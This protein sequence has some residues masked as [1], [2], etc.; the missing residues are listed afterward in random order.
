M[1]RTEPTRLLS[2]NQIAYT[3]M[4]RTRQPRAKNIAL[5]SFGKLRDR[6]QY[7]NIPK[8]HARQFISKHYAHVSW[9]YCSFMT[10]H[11][12]RPVVVRR[13]S[14]TVQ[15]VGVGKRLHEAVKLRA[16]SVFEVDGRCRCGVHSVSLAFP[17][18]GPSIF[19]PYLCNIKQT[20]CHV[21]IIFN[22]FFLFLPNKQRLG[23]RYEMRFLF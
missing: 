15:R 1:R 4:C 3:T 5:R 16:E 2:I 18:L 6:F 11:L 22:N 23:C 21:M 12:S 19:E 9:V 13:V 8:S 10:S 17:P 14:G 20:R 7:Q